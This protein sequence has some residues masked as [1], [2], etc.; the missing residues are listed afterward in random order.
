MSRRPDYVI[1][2]A[3]I[4]FKNFQERVNTHSKF[5]KDRGDGKSVNGGSFCIFL[6]Q[7]IAEE[8]ESRGVRVDE[9]VDKRKEDAEP[10]P[11]LRVI[12][13]FDP[14]NDWKNPVIWQITGDTHVKLDEDTMAGLDYMDFVHADVKLNFG[15]N[16][17]MHGFKTYLNT[18]YIEIPNDDLLSKY[19]Y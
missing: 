5:D 11:M 15:K 1:E 16:P 13:Q 10:Q 7:D 17:G 8:L 2:N 12:V 9:F 14:L 19:G 3:D 6:P 18:A 4:R